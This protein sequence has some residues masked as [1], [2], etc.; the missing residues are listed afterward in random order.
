MRYRYLRVSARKND[1]WTSSLLGFSEYTLRMPEKP[2]SDRQC[3]SMACE[4][5]NV[6]CGIET[7]RCWIFVYSLSYR[8]QCHS[9]VKLLTRIN[10]TQRKLSTEFEDKADW[11][12]TS[13]LYK[14]KI[15][16]KVW[17]QHNHGRIPRSAHVLTNSHWN[18]I[19]KR[20]LYVYRKLK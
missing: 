17:T 8:I 7:F 12:E 11:Y 13:A 20:L 1:C 5:V 18:T 16:I 19:F 2:P 14:T 15:K 3:F 4:K 10:W 6:F 9:G